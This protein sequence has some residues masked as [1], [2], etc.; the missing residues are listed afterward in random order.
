VRDRGASVQGIR[1]QEADS[2]RTRPLRPFAAI[3]TKEKTGPDRSPLPQRWDHRKAA[4]CLS[5]HEL[6]IGT[7]AVQWYNSRNLK[8]R[9]PFV[10]E[11]T[12]SPIVICVQCKLPITPEQRPSIQLKDGSELHAE[13]YEAYNRERRR[14]MQ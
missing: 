13:C 12:Q 14:N 11:E 1:S 6:V 4:R 8:L 2:T 5:R 9:S 3:G 10:R 7:L